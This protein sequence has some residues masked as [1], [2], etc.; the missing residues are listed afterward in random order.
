MLQAGERCGLG[1]QVLPD[2]VSGGAV[3]ECED[4]SHE[5]Q[6]QAFKVIYVLLRQLVCSPMGGATGVRVEVSGVD[7][8][9]SGPIVI[10]R[11]GY[12]VVLA[13]EVDHL[14][15]IGAVAYDVTEA[16]DL[17][18]GGTGIGVGQDG[19]ECLEVS[20]DIGQD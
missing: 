5:G 18:D 4:V 20:M 16:P 8:A 3:G 2:G 6:G 9:D 11:N 14:A 17:V 12:V 19:L 10:A 1:D 15:G 13:E 7:L